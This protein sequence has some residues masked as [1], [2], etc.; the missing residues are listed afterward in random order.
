APDAADGEHDER[1]RDGRED[2]V[3]S[4]AVGRSHGGRGYSG[5]AREP[6]ASSE[7]SGPYRAGASCVATEVRPGNVQPVR[8]AISPARRGP[9]LLLAAS[10]TTRNPERPS[11]A[12]GQPSRNRL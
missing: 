8:A 3:L 10:A 12:G 4:R 1:D 5:A 7:P 2:A 11:F 6:T 9:A